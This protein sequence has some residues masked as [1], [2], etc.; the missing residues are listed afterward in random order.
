MVSAES[1][2]ASPATVPVR[3]VDCD[4]HPVPGSM[5]EFIEHYPEPFR[6][7]YFTRYREEVPLSFLLYTPHS[8]T[9]GNQGMGGPGGYATPP[10]GGSGSDPDFL[11]KQLC[12]DNGVDYCIMNPLFFRPRHWDAEWDVAQAA[13]TNNWLAANWLEGEANRHGRFFGSI[14]VSSMDAE[15]AARE[16]ERWAG[17]PAFIQSYMLADSFVPFGAPQFEPLLKASARHDLPLATHLYRHSGIRSMTPVGFPSYHVEVLPNWIFTYICHVTSTVFEGVFERYPNLK[18]VAVEGGCEWVGP[19]LWRL[20][21]QWEE[22][23]AEVP[24]SSR[25][26]SEVI[27]EHVRFATQPLCEPPGRGDLARF[28]EW[29]GAEETIVFSSDYPHYDFDPA[30]WVTQQL[31]EAWRDRVMAKNALET[32]GL[33]AQRPRDY[34]D[35]IVPENPRKEAGERRYAALA[36]AA[37]GHGNAETPW[38]ESA[39]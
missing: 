21:R 30:P 32:Y 7:R 31:P 18:F 24:Q 39:D 4:V 27:R 26:P 20:D 3:V 14:Q 11:A 36:A 19:L 38:I 10:R 35:D 34:L 16:V 13:A 12:V 22:L 2:E 1:R 29:G 25:R 17:H 5:E 37:A 9:G 28:M 15:A 8:N 23:R 6:S 33:P